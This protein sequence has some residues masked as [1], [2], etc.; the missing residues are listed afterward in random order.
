M[1]IVKLFRS[2]P[3]EV[4]LLLVRVSPHPTTVGDLQLPW[5]HVD[6]T[7]VGT[8]ATGPYD[9]PDTRL[10]PTTPPYPRRQLG[11]R[12]PQT[13]RV[14]VGRAERTLI[15]SRTNCQTLLPPEGQLPTLD[16]EQLP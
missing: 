9:L 14:V 1:S 2:G 16:N 15:P 3:T 13:H 12:R 10:H 7:R 5:G 11:F 8:A 6:G 4:R